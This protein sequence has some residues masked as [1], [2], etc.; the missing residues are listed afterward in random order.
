MQKE[1]FLFSITTLRNAI[2]RRIQYVNTCWFC[3][4]VKTF[5]DIF[6]S[7]D[8]PFNAH[9]NLNS[10]SDLLLSWKCWYF[11][12]RSWMLGKKQIGRFYCIFLNF[13]QHCFICRPSISTVSEDSG[14]EPSSQIL[15]PWLGDIVDYDI[16]L[17]TI[18]RS[19]CQ[20]SRIWLQDFGISSQP[21]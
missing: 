10:L 12:L 9:T 6:I 8:S 21:L 17:S 20:G 1:I 16:G 11:H 5:Q 3:C 13:I 2:I 14:I 18:S 4:T 15:S 19:P 7:W